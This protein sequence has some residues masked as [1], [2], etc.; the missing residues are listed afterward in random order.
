MPETVAAKTGTTSIFKKVNG[1]EVEI[2]NGLIITF[3]PY[4][5][6]EIAVAV[7]VEGAKSGGS[8]SPV[9]SAVMQQYFTASS[10]EE[11]LQSEG[12]LLQ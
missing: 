6:P 5:D 12:V 10:F 11:V 9:A 8:T 3:A 2:N 4:D 1:K 7:I